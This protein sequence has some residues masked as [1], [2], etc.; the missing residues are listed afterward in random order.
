MQGQ[1]IFHCYSFRL[2]HFLQSQGVDYIYKGRNKNNHLIYY[3]FE[4]S[5]KVDRSIRIWNSLKSKED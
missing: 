2:A 1:S 5:D 3:A 4:K